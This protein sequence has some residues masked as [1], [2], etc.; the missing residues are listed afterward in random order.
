MLA[1][2]FDVEGKPVSL[3]R[4]WLGDG[5]KA[6]VDEPRRIMPGPLPEGACVRLSDVQ[7]QLGL[8]EGIETALA[9]SIKFQMPV[10]SCLNAPMLAKWE[11]PRGVESITIF[12]DND[13]NFTG[14]AAAYTLAR[15]MVAK[16]LEVAVRIP[17]K[18]GTDWAD[19]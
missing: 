5:E 16:K 15:R 4:T 14:Q 8:A 11:P 19:E 9:A 13:E 6:L 3:H 1:V 2:V 12:G 10:W 18:P 17:D 7:G